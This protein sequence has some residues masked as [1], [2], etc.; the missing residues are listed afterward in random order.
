MSKGAV[1]NFPPSISSVIPE[2]LQLEDALLG[3]RI[4]QAIGV[5]WYYQPCFQSL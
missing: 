1:P 5:R 3:Q 4:K 2:I